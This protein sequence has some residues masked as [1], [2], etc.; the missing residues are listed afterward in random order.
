[1]ALVLLLCV[2]LGFLGTALLYAV[3]EPERVRTGSSLQTQASSRSFGIGVLMGGILVLA[4]AI[5]SKLPDGLNGFIAI[6]ILG[7]YAYLLITGFTMVSQ[8]V[9]DKIQSNTASRTAGSTFFAV[10]YGGGLLLLANFVPI[11]GQIVLLI[12]VIL[13]IGTATRSVSLKRREKRAARRASQDPVPP[14]AADP[15]ADTTH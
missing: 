15:E 2:K 14:E 6:P 10:L 3:L 11:I 9:G 13:S 5:V 7:A 8:C 4:C 12:V 1:M